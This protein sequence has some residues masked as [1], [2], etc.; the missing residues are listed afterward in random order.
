[1][2]KAKKTAKKTVKKA[3]VPAPAAKTAAPAKKG[4]TLMIV[5]AALVAFT[6][7]EIYFVVQKTLR[8]S[9][10]PDFVMSWP[11]E[12]KKGLTSLGEYGN[13]LYAVDSTTTGNVYKTSKTDGKTVKLFTLPELVYGAV[14]D[15]KGFVYIL[16]KQN[17][18]H[19]YTPDNVEI[20]KI[21][22][23]DMQ[24]AAWI[25]VDSKDNFYIA[26]TTTSF[27]TKYDPSFNKVTR[28]GGRGEGKDKF[29]N[30]SKI[31]AGPNDDLYCVNSLRTYTAS[32]KIL[33]SNG[34][35]KKE[36]LFKNIK[37]I[38]SQENM[39][40][41]KDGFVYVNSFEGSSI[42]VFDNNGKF[43]GNFDTDKSKRFLITFPSSITGGKDGL[44]YISTHDLAVFQQV[45]Y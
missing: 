16:D 12:Y 22:L 3:A 37:K 25:E 15:S 6:A 17:T 33:D 32:M 20:K 29:V 27:I 40:I 43:M 18:V 30:L 19:K 10:R 8:Q 35:F 13:F 39:A 45:K 5:L 28:F 42:Y 11:S 14:E 44:I 23:A 34:K 36:W 38:S 21:P 41:T 26:D 2:A 31:F 24:S 1:M 4:G 7:I 9:K